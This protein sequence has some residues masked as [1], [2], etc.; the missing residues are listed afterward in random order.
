MRTDHPEL[1]DPECLIDCLLLSTFLISKHEELVRFLPHFHI[2][3][4]VFLLIVRC[5]V[6]PVAFEEDD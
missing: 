2:L 1:L 4:N 5:P 3:P 6:N